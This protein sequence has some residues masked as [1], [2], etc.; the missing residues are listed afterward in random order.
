MIRTFGPTKTSAATKRVGHVGLVQLDQAGKL[1]QLAV[2]TSHLVL[3]RIGNDACGGHVAVF[4][5]GQQGRQAHVV[6][7]A[8]PHSKFPGVKVLGKVWQTA[9]HLQQIVVGLVV[10]L[11]QKVNS[12]SFSQVGHVGHVT[13]WVNRLVGMVGMVG[14]VVTQT[15]SLSQLCQFIWCVWF[16]WCVWSVWCWY[17]LC[18]TCKSDFA[19]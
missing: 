3:H 12:Q 1:G 5:V 11:F 2:Q 10:A 8:A 7:P 4:D 18:L 15:G 16:V 17:E 13:V 14:M 6:Q 9:C 19:L